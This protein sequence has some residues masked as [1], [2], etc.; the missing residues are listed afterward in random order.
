MGGGGGGAM[1]G[2]AMGASPADEVG[3]GECSEGAGMAG[4]GS[5]L[6]E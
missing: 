5:V 2:G 4:G 6:A 3:A 1:L